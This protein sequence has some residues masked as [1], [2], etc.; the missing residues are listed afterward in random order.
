ML[1]TRAINDEEHTRFYIFQVE[2]IFSHE[3]FDK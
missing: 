1:L 3:D 2:N